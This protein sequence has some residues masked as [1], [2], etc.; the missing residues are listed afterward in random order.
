MYRLLI[1]LDRG[2]LLLLLLETFIGLCYI[3]VFILSITIKLYN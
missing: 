2:I 3:I 1:F